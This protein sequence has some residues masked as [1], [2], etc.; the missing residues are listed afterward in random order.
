MNQGS[1]K[2]D[3]KINHLNKIKATRLD[4]NQS[5]RKPPTSLAEE[6]P[7][8]HQQS[9]AFSNHKFPMVLGSKKNHSWIQCVAIWISCIKIELPTLLKITLFQ[10]FQ[11]DQHKAETPTRILVFVLLLIPFNQFSNIFL[12]FV[13]GGIV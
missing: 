7:I 5:P 6:I 3:T 1:H 2:V 10:L 11:I 4:I 13:E 8:D 12:I 9:I